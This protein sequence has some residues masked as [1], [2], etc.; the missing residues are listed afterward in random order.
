MSNK[1]ETE[2]KPFNIIELLSRIANKVNEYNSEGN[3]EKV[4]SLHWVMEQIEQI[5][6]AAVT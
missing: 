2:N 4:D 1:Q 3:T 5:Y 6:K